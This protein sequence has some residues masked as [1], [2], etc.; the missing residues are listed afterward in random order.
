MDYRFKINFLEHVMRINTWA[1][2]RGA[3]V[4]IDALNYMLHVQLD[5]RHVPFFPQFV[6]RPEPGV[7]TYMPS[8]QPDTPALV[9]WLPYRP[10]AW[11]ISASKIAF[12]TLAESLG[13]RVPALWE[14]VEEVNAPYL[15]KLVRGSFGHGM[16]GPYFAEAARNLRLQPGEFCEEFKFG[17]IARAWYWDGVL[18]VLEA[19]EMP[20]VTA[21]GVSSYEQLLLQKSP[22]VIPHEV[23]PLAALQGVQLA[24]APPEGKQIVCDY[25]YASPLKST[26]Y[27]NANVLRLPQREPALQH[28][29]EA[30]R[31]IAPHLPLPEGQSSVGFVLDA[32]I[33]SDN[34]PWFLEINSNSQ[35]H[36]D[37]YPTMLDR[38]FKVEDL[39]TT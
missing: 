29:E 38:I 21:D 4:Q 2:R 3:Q 6:H 35:G 7:M 37:W 18:C 15:V 1:V 20:T 25:R 34:Q 33:D 23:Q 12:K 28:F 9:G 27:G 10:Q 5:D 16:R 39:P 13:L 24:D 8:P 32:I 11:D 14:R 19:F 17:R 31:L 22:E 36:P 30:G 26:T